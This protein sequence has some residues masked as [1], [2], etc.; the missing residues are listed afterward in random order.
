[1]RQ[2]KLKPFVLLFVFLLPVT[3]CNAFCAVSNDG[4][5]HINVKVSHVQD[6]PRTSSIQASIDGH[7]LS[8]VFLENLGQVYIGIMDEGG[9]EAQSQSTPTPN[10]VNF[11]LPIN[12]SYVI[13][14][15]L[16]NG[17]EYYGEFE[18]ND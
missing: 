6:Q 5:S 2:M 12:G 10:G 11:Y 3:F 8:V 17:D 16:P 14:F 15:T 18:V 13:T 7:W 1:M 9:G 4:H